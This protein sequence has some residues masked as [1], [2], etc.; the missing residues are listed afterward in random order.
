MQAG[1]LLPLR[2][3]LCPL[4]IGLR[5]VEPLLQL[6][7]PVQA[8]ALAL[9]A[10]VER[11]ELLLAVGEIALQP[12]EP[13]DRRRIGLLRQGELLDAHPVDLAL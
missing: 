3:A 7:D 12:L 5:L 9:P 4:E 2:V 10:G 13:G 11:G 1:R 8:A 6:A